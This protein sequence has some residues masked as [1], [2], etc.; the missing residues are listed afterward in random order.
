MSNPSSSPYGNNFSPI[1]KEFFKYMRD[2]KGKSPDTVKAYAEDLSIFFRFLKHYK[3]LSD[4]NI[5]DI[6]LDDIDESFVKS[7][8]LSD[9]YA[10]IN[11][12][13]IVRHNGPH[14]RAR[15]TASIRS[16]YKYINLSMNI[17]Y[18]SPVFY[19]KTPR[20]I[21]RS[22]NCLTEEEA[23]RL[24][25]SVDGMYKERDTAIITLFIDCG[26]KLDELVNINM[27]DIKGNT[28][29]VRFKG[30]CSTFNLGCR[31]MDALNCYL[32]I[33]PRNSG[34]E[35]LFLSERGNRI[36]KRTVQYIVQRY[37]KKA[38]LDGNGYSANRLRNNFH[39]HTEDMS[40]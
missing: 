12:I 26:L 13:T 9:I 33:R 38:N 32:K 3:K 31:S 30:G 27:E 7:I 28:L 17:E 18:Q 8:K 23:M 20:L 14:A 21:K 15:K 25:S 19:L 5:D 6:S 2:I 24:I 22:P 11:Y 39:L 16:F 40:L 37:I 29:I 10:F 34:S 4:K 1:M 36:S 35:A